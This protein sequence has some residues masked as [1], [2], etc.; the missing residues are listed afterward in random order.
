MN[1]V[2]FFLIVLAVIALVTLT[3]CTH[4]GGEFVGRSCVACVEVEIKGEADNE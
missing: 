1:G 3:A 4:G 2:S